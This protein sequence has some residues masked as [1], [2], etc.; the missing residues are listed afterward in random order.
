MN[1]EDLHLAFD[2]LVFLVIVLPPS[3]KSI[4]FAMNMD[5]HLSRFIAKTT[6]F[7]GRREH[8]RTLHLKTTLS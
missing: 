6:L 7:L 5:K 2:C 8:I 4:V 3:E 1:C